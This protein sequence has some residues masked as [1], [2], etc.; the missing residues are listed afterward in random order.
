VSALEGRCLFV[1][2]DKLYKAVKSAGFS[3]RIYANRDDLV[4]QEYAS[5]V[6]GMSVES[7]GPLV[8]SALGHT[9][10][11]RFDE[12]GPFVQFAS[13]RWRPVPSQRMFTVC[14]ASVVHYA[15]SR[16]PWHANSTKELLRRAQN[17]ISRVSR[18]TAEDRPI[19]AK[20]NEWEI[21]VG[22]E[23][24]WEHQGWDPVVDTDIPQ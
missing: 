1:S 13:K 23:I 17:A 22:D 11:I 2:T 8:K 14:V 21:R 16:R 24:W 12:H 15:H 7:I 5:I 3:K 6:T 20:K 18:Y 4:V 10:K 9:R 19:V